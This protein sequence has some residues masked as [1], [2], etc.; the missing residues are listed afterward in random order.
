MPLPDP[1]PIARGFRLDRGDRVRATRALAWLITATTALRFLPYATVTRAIARI[2]A[3]RT[4]ITPAECAT[5]IRRAATIWPA[6]C[7]PQAI[8]GYCLLRRGG[9]APAV[10]LGVALDRRDFAAHAWLECDGVVVT[11]GDVD[12]SYAP[13]A[14]ERQAR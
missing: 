9:L 12:R 11:G 8:A 3:G 2:P 7:L 14:R 13:L 1:R 6:R 4:P 5:A 10:R